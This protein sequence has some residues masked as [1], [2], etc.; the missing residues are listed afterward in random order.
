[1]STLSV[2]NGAPVSNADHSVARVVTLV[3]ELITIVEEENRALARGLPAS[4][5]NST[6]RK[7]ALAE[8]VERWAMHLRRHDLGSAATDRGQRERLVERVRRLTVVMDENV[9]RLRAAITASQRRVDAIMRAVREDV[10]ARAPYGRNGRVAGPGA[11]A[12]V[13]GKSIRV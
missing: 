9:T 12:G 2:E 6:A 4:L 5:S 8:D 3:D 1:M 7:T 13:C 11:V 10:A